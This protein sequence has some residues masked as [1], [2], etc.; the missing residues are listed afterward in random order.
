[1]SYSPLAHLAQNRI[2]ARVYIELRTMDL[3]HGQ[4]IHH[5]L[6]RAMMHLNT[7]A[8]YLPFFEPAVD[9]DDPEPY[10][11]R[12]PGQMAPHAR[13]HLHTFVPAPTESPA[14][15]TK[16]VS[17]RDAKSHYHE[18]SSTFSTYR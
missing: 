18:P 5:H 13:R 6:A 2:P 7:L 3:S 12:R 8:G 14:A 1:M 4:E 10:M 17:C 16:G 15:T 11:Y 9:W